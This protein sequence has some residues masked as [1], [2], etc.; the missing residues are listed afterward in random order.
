MTKQA[1]QTTNFLIRPIG[2]V[3]LLI[4]GWLPLLPGNT[5]VWVIDSSWYYTST[6][7]WTPLESFVRMAYD[8][9]ENYT[10]EAVSRGELS[11]APIEELEIPA[12]WTGQI[13]AALTVRNDLPVKAGWTFLLHVD[14]GE[15]YLQKTSGN[16]ERRLFGS[17]RPRP[18][19]D[20]SRHD[21]IF[22]S[23]YIVQLELAPGARQEILIRLSD[24]SSHPWF[25]LR[26]MSRSNFLRNSI[27]MFVGNN[28]IQGI[29]HGM[30]WMMI[31]FSLGTFFLKKDR[32]YLYLA[33]YIFSVSIFLFFQ[34][35]MDKA[36]WIAD[37]P[38]LSRVIS[39]AALNGIV[40]FYA[41]LIIHFLHRDGWR[42]D[43]RKL[44]RYY[45]FTA[46][47]GG[48]L[49]TFLLAVAPLDLYNLTTNV[50]L[51]FPLPLLG[52]LGLLYICYIYLR[53]DNILA[54]FFAITNLCLFFGSI[55]YYYW[56]YAG[57]IAFREIETYLWP[58]WI[59]QAG[60]ILQMVALVLSIGYRDLQIEREKVRLEEMDHVKS[61][62]FANISH[63]FRTPLTLIL[64]PLQEMKNKSSDPWWQEQFNLIQRNARRLLKLINQI[65]DLS[66]LDSGKVQ[67][68]LTKNNI[69]GLTKA[70]AFSFQSLL[71]HKEIDLDFES[72]TDEIFLVFDREKIEQVLL[73]LLSNAL[74][75][76]PKGGKI[77]VSLAEKAHYVLISIDNTGPGI[78]PDHLPHLFE[79]FYQTGTPGY[80]TDQPSTGIGLAL[81]KEWINLHGGQIRVD[82]RPG[83]L[84]RFQLQLPRHLK[85]TEKQ[86]AKDK[87]NTLSAAPL[88]QA[89][90]VKSSAILQKEDSSLPNLLIVEDNPDIRDYIRKGLQEQYQITEATDGEAG[91]ELATAS[92]PDL[93]LTDVMM[94]RLDGF[95]LCRRL[96]A[97]EATSHIPIILLTGKASRESR[98][99]GLSTQA[100]DFLAKP[101]DAEELRL[102]IRNLLHNRELWRKRFDQPGLLDPSPVE[103]P[104]REQ[105]F[106]QQAKEIIEENLGD[107]SFSVE[108]LSRALALDRTQLFRKLR[109]LTGQNPSRFIRTIR[110]KRA[111]Q[112]LE[113]K[114]GTAAEIAFMVGF[115]SSSYFSKCFKEEFGKTPGEVMF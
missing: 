26:A 79:R 82:S 21:P 37:Y 42:P 88:A 112:L 65:L 46:V 103:I 12:L 81:T 115:S 110:L 16:W 94:P 31:F 24:R 61:R 48:T 36:F 25:E 51:L 50:W 35:E 95:E 106:L 77:T 32:T 54:R 9:E 23:P 4:S 8:P 104:S 7:Q 113:G 40:I 11:L 13:W 101:F 30:C 74:K 49:T 64:G 18:E 87:T 107:E 2:L 10:F 98:L 96:K 84:T 99:E 41:L 52:L 80:T 91:L 105:A 102:R 78:A 62:F 93:I 92:V 43:L 53:S 89:A 75:Y 44:L 60:F 108:Q 59:M 76:T 70:L 90:S 114:V 29:F 111:K 28:W 100:D 73:N 86:S 39:N 71:E 1:S 69:A 45:F 33:S 14:Q 68:Q 27:D 17:N 63:E 3:L 66:K 97:Q 15:M 38:R 72:E 19:W 22:P 55:A 57:L 58:V 83:G 109:A 6:P 5:P 47:F 85:A 34:M 56:S 67:L 20:A